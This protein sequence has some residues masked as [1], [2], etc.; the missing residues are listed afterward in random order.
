[1][2]HKEL[3][4]VSTKMLVQIR[5]LVSLIKD[6]EYS[7]PLALLSGNTIAKHIR[8]V[9]E[10][11]S[12]L[13]KGLKVHLV[14]YDARSRNLL[15]EH[16]QEYTIQFINDLIEQLSI[17]PNDQPIQLRVCFN[18]EENTLDVQTTL[19]RELAYNIEHAI[20]HMAIIQIAIKHSFSHIKLDPQ[21]GVAYS[22]QTNMN[23]NV[24]S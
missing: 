5:E 19:N 3:T 1:M 10:I 2:I 4:Q 18:T 9:L 21:F 11:Y 20:H 16:N 24:Y 7:Q 17:F 15:I 23:K 12:E 22:T 14:N 8:H 6:N 13:V